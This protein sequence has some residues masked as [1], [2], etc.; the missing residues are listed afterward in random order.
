MFSLDTP[1][2][3]CEERIHYPV[4]NPENPRH[5]PSDCRRNS[6]N[7]SADSQ[8]QLHW[9]QD[10]HRRSIRKAQSG[11]LSLREGLLRLS[12]RNDDDNDTGSML[13]RPQSHINGRRKQA[14]GFPG[15]SDAST[16]EDGNFGLGLYRMNSTWPSASCEPSS[17]RSTQVASSLALVNVSAPELPVCNENTH[18]LETAIPRQVHISSDDP[19]PYSTSGDRP[20]LNVFPDANTDQGRVVVD[21]ERSVG[22]TL[23]QRLEQ[24][25]VSDWETIESG[26]YSVCSMKEDVP[27]AHEVCD[28]GEVPAE[29]PQAAPMAFW[30]V[31]AIAEQYT[32]YNPGLPQKGTVY[33]DAL[34]YEHET[35]NSSRGSFKL[36]DPDAPSIH[37]P[38]KADQSLAHIRESE[39]LVTQERLQIPHEKNSEARASIAS[40]K[41]SANVVKIAFPGLYH[42]LLE[43]WTRETRHL[44]VNNAE[45]GNNSRSSH[46]P[47][48]SVASE[49]SRQESNYHDLPWSCE[50]RTHGLSL[51]TSTGHRTWDSNEVISCGEHSSTSIEDIWVQA[52]VP[53]RFRTSRP[54]RTTTPALSTS[55]THAHPPAEMLN[56]N[57]RHSFGLHIAPG[58]VSV[59]TS[60]SKS[61][62][63]LTAPRSLA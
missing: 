31:P 15:I 5:N 62:K 4:Y 45:T 26:K 38:R 22:G 1:Q 33:E 59:Q 56:T 44:I 9:V 25:D 55:T 10:L 34:L 58:T 40:R 27:E 20:A 48:S 42:A 19:P 13:E 32:A 24:S 51:N 21:T 61:K 18:C 54:T 35:T 30:E 3:T 8:K 7:S 41:C 53:L 16:Q 63:L 11:L 17:T 12:T 6:Q 47:A 50:N 14:Y 46:I 2:P 52:G 49:R 36:P 57:T 29:Q 23:T 28:T 60:P 43:Q 39:A 37:G